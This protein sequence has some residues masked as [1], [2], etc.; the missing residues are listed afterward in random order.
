MMRERMSP[1]QLV[2]AQPVFAAA[3]GAVHLLEFD[4]IAD[5][6]LRMLL[7]CVRQGDLV[8]LPGQHS[9]HY[10]SDGGLGPGLVP[11]GRQLSVFQ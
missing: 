7:L 8:V 1:P 3:S 10:R 9:L 2:G 11:E 4:G 6:C 5:L